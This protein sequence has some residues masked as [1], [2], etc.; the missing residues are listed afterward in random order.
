MN[1]LPVII[2]AVA[3]NQLSLLF[4]NIDQEDKMAVYFKNDEGMEK[5]ESVLQPEGMGSDDANR[6]RLIGYAGHEFVLRSSDMKF[7]ASTTVHVNEDFADGDE[8]HKYKITFQ[9]LM[10]DDEGASMEIHSN[11]YI[12]IDPGKSHQFFSNQNHE[13]VLR[14]A[15]NVP[16]VGLT[17]VEV[18]GGDEL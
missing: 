10:G 5:L 4:R 16:K 12:W 14:N 6:Y 7:R 2:A 1:L 18:E 15:D 17:L 11:G 8:G 3:A 9:N 13:F